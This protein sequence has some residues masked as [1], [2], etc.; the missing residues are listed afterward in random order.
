MKPGPLSSEDSRRRALRRA[1]PRPLSRR[2]PGF[3]WLSLAV[4][5]ATAGCITHPPITDSARTGPFFK[6]VNYVGDPQLPVSLRRVVLLPVHGAPFAD[7]ATC[8][9]L[10]PVVAEAL[11]RQMRFEVVS[12]T[13]DECARSFGV[14]DLDSTSALPAG[15]LDSLAR[16]FGAQGVMFVDLTAYRPY[17]PMAIGFRA[18][19]ALV[20]GPRIVWTFDQVF[21]TE[22]SAVA[23]SL[24]HFYIGGDRQG[25]P[26]D[27]TPDTLTSP[28]R[29]AEYVAYTAFHTLPP[30]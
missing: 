28:T 30:P 27:E 18:K 21:S 17:R 6:P 24:R 11:G 19:L 15:F 22:N 12:L 8:E 5:M 14:Y 29:F 13:R 10:D 9:L 16:E 25:L 2:L 23:N 7:G 1:G 4:L 20:N 3:A 26:F